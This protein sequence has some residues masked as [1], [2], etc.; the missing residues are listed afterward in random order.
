VPTRP[1]PGYELLEV[2]VQPDSPA[3]G[4]QIGEVHWP[5]GSAVVAVTHGREIHAA[6]PE[7]RLQA[8]ERVLVLTPIPRGTTLD[9]E[10]VTD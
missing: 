2:R 9:L 8:G 10:I 1:L 3:L 7:L 4:K 5:P 6:A